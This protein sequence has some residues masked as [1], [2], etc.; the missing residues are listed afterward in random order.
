MSRRRAATL[1]AALLLAGCGSEGGD[2]SPSDPTAERPVDGGATAGGTMLATAFPLTSVLVAAER[3]LPSEVSIGEI[4]LDT[5]W[6][7][8][9]RI[10]VPLLR[11]GV[12][13]TLTVTV[14]P[15]REVCAAESEVLSEAEEDAVAIEVCTVWEDEGRLPVVVPDPDAPIE[16]DPSDAAR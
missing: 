14:L 5:R 2:G 8:G 4:P 9:N 15:G 12:A 6:L 11:D 1:V 16:V 3:T 13:A 7:P 10:E